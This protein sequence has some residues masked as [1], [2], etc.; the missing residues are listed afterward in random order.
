VRA[1]KNARAVL[2]HHWLTW[3]QLIR[4]QHVATHF[5]CHVS[6]ARNEVAAHLFEPCWYDVQRG[7]K[8]FFVVVVVVLLLV[9]CTALPSSLARRSP[10]SM[11]N[12]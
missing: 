1:H 10:C 11:A 2:P 6:D 8:F 12:V 5:F 4:D 7:S 9:V 3:G